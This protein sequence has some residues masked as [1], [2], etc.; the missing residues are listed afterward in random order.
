LGSIKGKWIKRMAENL[1][2]AYPDRFNKDFENNKNVLV[3]L[4]LIYHKSVRNKLAG[5][6]RNLIEE[7]N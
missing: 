4:N 5:Y 7:N 1:I 2:K 3:E 6:I